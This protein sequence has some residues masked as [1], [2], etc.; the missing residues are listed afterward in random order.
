MPGTFYTSLS[1]YPKHQGC[2]STF[3]SNWFCEF[4]NLN[5][6]ARKWQSWD[7]QREVS[8]S[9]ILCFT[10]ITFI[11]CCCSV[12]TSSHVLSIN[13]LESA[14]HCPCSTGLTTFLLT[15]R[16]HHFANEDEA[17][18]IVCMV[19]SE[20]ASMQSQVSE[21]Q[22]LAFLPSSQAVSPWNN[23]KEVSC[24]KAWTFSS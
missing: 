16:H 18:E 2:F 10:I 12:K 19:V 8:N 1:P 24:T 23:G 7:W 14:Q 4:Y 22:I 21:P 17:G 9:K 11:P 6:P 20:D 13:R 3:S 5:H 15:G